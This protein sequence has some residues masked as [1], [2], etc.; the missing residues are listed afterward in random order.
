[1]SGPRRGHDVGLRGPPAA[2]TPDHLHGSFA[3]VSLVL[4]KF[5]A[6][7]YEARM[8]AVELQLAEERERVRSIGR[9]VEVLHDVS[10]GLFGWRSLMLLVVRDRAVRPYADALLD[11]ARRA[12]AM[13]ERTIARTRRWAV[14]S[15]LLP[16]QWQEAATAVLDLRKEIEG[17]LGSTEQHLSELL[18]IPNARLRLAGIKFAEAGGRLLAAVRAELEVVVGRLEDAEDRAAIQDA[19]EFDEP[20][21]SLDDVIA[22]QGLTR[23][24]LQS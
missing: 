1:M 22:Q 13:E 17:M 4:P 19:S 15:D 9:E 14:Y 5:A 2:P 3:N 8:S 20:R 12:I 6:T 21:V 23:G 18:S 10:E 11:S 16:T 7:L 24:D